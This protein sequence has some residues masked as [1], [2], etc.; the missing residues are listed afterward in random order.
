M[1]AVSEAISASGGWI[2]DHTLFSNIMATIRFAIPPA[3][4]DDLKGRIMAAGIRLETADRPEPQQAG[5]KDPRPQ[6]EILGSLNLTF[7]HNDP[8]LRIELPAVPG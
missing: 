6:D 5:S 2:V 7:I 4:L 8:D 1:M 3:G